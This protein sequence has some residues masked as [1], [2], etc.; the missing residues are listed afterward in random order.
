MK[1]FLKI[2]GGLLVLLLIGLAIFISTF[3]VNKYKPRMITVVKE[4]TGRNFDITGDLKMAYSLIPT[5]AVDGVS[6]GNAK[7]GSQPDMAKI[8]HFEAR[9]ALL[10]LM[11]GNLYIRRLVLSDTDIFLETSKDGTG[12]WQLELPP[13]KEER[14]VAP[15][16][17]DTRMPALHISKVWI[18][19]AKITYKDG[20][21]GKT[22][23]ARI[24]E[25]D[26]ATG[27]FTEPL[28]LSLKAAYNDIPLA[29]DG[30]MG[31][32][33]SLSGNKSS[34]LALN[35]KINDVLLS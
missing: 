13:G 19:N 35:L 34:P 28:T 8:G 10:P 11:H 20:V 25:L 32:L 4:K 14:P 24:D 18:R 15:S 31:S 3:D 29:A 33:S 17:T 5:V 6:F 26:A 16:P 23:T 22:K 7:W 27:G 9:I 30:S 2:I 1:L 12:N 21:S